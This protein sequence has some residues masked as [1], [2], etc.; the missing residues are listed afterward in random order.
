MLLESTENGLFCAAGDFYIDPWRAVDRA[1]IT[2]AHGDHARSGNKAYLCSDVGVDVL[3]QRVG[4]EANIQGVPYGQA[5]TLNGV[6]ITLIPAGHILGSAQVRVEYGGEI[7]VFSGDYNTHPNPTCA[8]FEPVRCHTF[9]GESTFG[10]PIYHW[11]DSSRVFAQIHDW[12]R[13]N[14]AEGICSILFAYSLGKA[15]RLLNQIDASRGPIYAH[16][17]VHS[18]TPAYKVAGIALPEILRATDKGTLKDRNKALVIA[19]TSARGSPWLRRFG[20]A[21]HAFASGWM[22]VR[23]ARR[24]RNVDRGFVLSDHADWDGLLST[25]RDTGCERVGVTHGFTE[26]LSAWFKE[27]GKD[28][29]I[30][31][32]EYGEDIE[33]PAGTINP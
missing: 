18:F 10:L 3:R 33:Q 8:P 23:G 28:S 27:Q 26:P 16:G 9:I 13:T 4:A 24:R 25:I 5:L 22:A 7:W 11:E 14:Q 12:W 30:L 1:V 2:H 31:H 32:T 29:F 15:Q 19:P 6:H 20:L 17:S 21:S